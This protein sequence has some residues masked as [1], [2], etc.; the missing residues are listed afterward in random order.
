MDQA[1]LEQEAL[2]LPT[3]A[4][5]LL[6]EALLES[7]DDDAAR[8]VEASWGQEAEARLQAFHRGELKAVDG[9]G[10]FRDLRRQ[11]QK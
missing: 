5:A 4:R 2:R 11:H 7:L 8:A 1:I 3:R 6:A 9:P 10:V